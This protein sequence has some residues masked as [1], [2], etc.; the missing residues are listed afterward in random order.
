MD[1]IAAALITGLLA[2]AGVIITNLFA[3]RKVEAVPGGFFAGK[4]FGLALL[5][6]H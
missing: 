4:W 6:P 2:L 5:F 1:S 3:G